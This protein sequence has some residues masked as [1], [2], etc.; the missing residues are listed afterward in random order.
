M[1]PGLCPFS[2]YFNTTLTLIWCGIFFI[3]KQRETE[4]VEK[5]FY[6]LALAL[7]IQQTVHNYLA[8]ATATHTQK[9]PT[10][11]PDIGATFDLNIF[12]KIGSRFVISLVLNYM[13]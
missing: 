8:L 9:E 7:A 12:P 2:G 13:R 1:L 5:P 11:F 10:H 3:P 6:S 4:G